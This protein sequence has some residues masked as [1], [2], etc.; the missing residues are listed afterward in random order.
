MYEYEI[1]EILFITLL[2]KVFMT[3]VCVVDNNVVGINDKTL[4]SILLTII[5]FRIQRM[6][7]KKRRW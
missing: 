1:R 5:M 4:W 3:A 7:A 2:A 6:M